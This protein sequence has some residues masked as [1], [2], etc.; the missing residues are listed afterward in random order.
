MSFHQGDSDL[1]RQD[2]FGMGTKWLDSACP[3]GREEADHALLSPPG[4]PLSAARA[5]GLR[6]LDVPRRGDSVSRSRGIRRR[7]LFV[8]GILETVDIG[9]N[10]MKTR[11]ER[12]ARLV[13]RSVVMTAL[14]LGLAML[15]VSTS[16]VGGGNLP[17]DEPSKG[18]SGPVTG[19]GGGQPEPAPAKLGLIVNDPRAFPG[20]TLIAPLNSRKTYLIDELGRVVKT[21]ES[22]YEAG[23]EA[24]L[25]ENGHLLRAAKLDDREQMF[26]GA[27]RGGRIQEFDLG[28]RARSGTSSS[29]TTRAIGHHAICRLPNG[30]VLLLVWEIKTAEEAVA[31]GRKPESVRGPWLADSVAEVKPTGKTTGEVVWEWHAWDHL[32]QD[33]DPSK[34]NYGDVGKYPERIDVN[35]GDGEIGFPGGGPPGP[36]RRDLAKKE[37]PEGRRGEEEEGN[38]PA[39][40]H[41]LR[42]Q[43]DGA[44]QPGDPPRLDPRQ[45]RGLQRRPRSDHTL[46]STTSA[47]SGSSITAPPRKRRPVSKRGANTARGATS[48]IA[49]A[50][51]RGPTAAAPTP[52]SV[53]SASTTPTGFRRDCRERAACDRLQQWHADGPTAPVPPWTR[54]SCRSTRTAATIASPAWLSGPPGRVVLCGS[55][56]GG[57]VLHGHVRRQ[58]ATQRQHAHMLQRRRHGLRG[59]R[60]GETVW[61]YANPAGGGLSMGLPGGPPMGGPKSR[62]WWS[63]FCRLWSSSGS[64]CPPGAED[65]VR[66]D[67][68]G[69]RG[70]TRDDLAASRGSGSSIRL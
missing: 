7:S 26:G 38:G 2:P 12:R 42:R 41:R 45:Q 53:S 51:P 35:F 46:A 32:I 47:R 36:P 69:R 6:N 62:R 31:A 11:K 67:T 60:D 25:L 50:I 19:P 64:T 15:G 33:A 57:A 48:S 61:K 54:S 66:R 23:Q 65:E 24:Y 56:Q 55:E 4:R 44:G 21:W 40:E 37:R 17:A 30:N 9:R 13:E 39:Q 34:A 16:L 20:Y 52:T 14:A 63:M 28:R 59:E 22:K 18:N 8:L 1:A 10:L 70:Q 3:C 5:K 43:P 27:G 68:E 49:G 58:S 29:T